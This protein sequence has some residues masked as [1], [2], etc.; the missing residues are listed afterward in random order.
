[1]YYN[2]LPLPSNYELQQAKNVTNA[3]ELIG[4]SLDSFLHTL[5]TIYGTEMDAVIQIARQKPEWKEPLNK[6][7]EILA[8]VVFA[9]RNEMAVHLLDVLQRRTGLGTLGLPNDETL[10]KIADTMA[11][12]LG[13]NQQ[14]ISKEIEIAK[15]YLRLPFR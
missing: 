3:S 2:V 12:E 5:A 15:N 1:M 8:Q 11:V 14:Q 10:Q 9:V 13:W 4:G 7:G 6:D